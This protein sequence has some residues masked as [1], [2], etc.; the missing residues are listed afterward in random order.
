MKEVPEKP[1]LGDILQDTW[2]VLLKTVKVIKNKD[3]LRNYHS[4]EELKEIKPPKA[5]LI[6]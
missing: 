1:Q 6:S 5:M 4:Q 3:S 2:S